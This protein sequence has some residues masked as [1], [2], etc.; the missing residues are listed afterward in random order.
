MI[1]VY[2]QV[3]HCLHPDR[4]VALSVDRHIVKETTIQVIQSLIYIII[5]LLH[6]YDF[7]V[8]CQIPSMPRRRA[9]FGLF[10][11]K[12]SKWTSFIFQRP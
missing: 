6:N 9:Y 7:D 3:D 12:H 11:I 5:I 1:A 4:N 10:N 2:Q 8:K